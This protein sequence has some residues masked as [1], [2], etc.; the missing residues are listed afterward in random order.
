[1]NG[2]RSGGCGDHRH[3]S[4]AGRPHYAIRIYRF[5]A[6]LGFNHFSEIRAGAVPG[7][8]SAAS[9]CGRGR[10][11]GVFSPASPSPDSGGGRVADD[12][13]GSRNHVDEA[14][15]SAC[16]GIGPGR[17]PMAEGKL[18]YGGSV[19]PS[20]RPVD[21]RLL[22]QALASFGHGLRAAIR[23]RNALE[24]AISRPGHRW[25]DSRCAERPCSRQV[26]HAAKR[27]ELRREIAAG[28]A[29]G[30][31]FRVYGLLRLI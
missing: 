24:G 9:I 8:A 25:Y 12:V 15:T 27:Q 2:I 28:P 1:M 13:R 11:S 6:S 5:R 16:M 17:L 26:L 29:R 10:R 30:H 19:L 21:S 18:R 7:R 23:G 31:V 3:S 22:A 4:S 14:G 20:T